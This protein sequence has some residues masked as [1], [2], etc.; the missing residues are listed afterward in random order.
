MLGELLDTVRER[1]P[2]QILAGCGVLIFAQAARKLA[3]P[4]IGDAALIPDPDDAVPEKPLPGG[5]AVTKLVA[6]FLGKLL[7][8]ALLGDDVVGQ[9][10]P[11]LA[12]APS[13][14][15]EPL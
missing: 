6:V 8:G 11:V 14:L 1:R 13:S 7:G 15:V 9:G 12:V 2:A 5:P 4:M 10:L 3:G